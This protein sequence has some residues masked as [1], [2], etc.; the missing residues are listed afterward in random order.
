MVFSHIAALELSEKILNHRSRYRD[1]F[2]PSRIKLAGLGSFIKE[3]V[4][5]V[6]KF[7]GKWFPV[8]DLQA[9]ADLAPGD[10]KVVK[11]E[12]HSIALHK[13]DIGNFHA[14]SPSCTHVHCSVAWNSAEKSWDCPCH[15]SRYSCDGKVLT[16][17]ASKDLEP[18]RLKHE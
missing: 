18:I 8:K 2:D 17:P 15:G 11:Y 13:D 5:V 7:L 3:Q 1:L 14:V 4:D 9:L 12:G 10:A 16:A 6:S